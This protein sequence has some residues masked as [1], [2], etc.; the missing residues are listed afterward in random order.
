MLRR[1]LPCLRQ[2][3]SVKHVS[4]VLALGC[5]R[6][7]TQMANSVGLMVGERG[8]EPP[9]PWSRTN[10][11]CTK[12]LFRLGLFCVLLCP[13]VWFSGANGPRL[14]PRLDSTFRARCKISTRNR[15]VLL[16][17]TPRRRFCWF[18]PGKYDSSVTGSTANANLAG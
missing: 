8:F 14:D 15:A 9:T 7:E 6:T 5:S 18:D 3:W 4:G 16:V 1:K 11:R 2:A 17:K 12:L 13:P 10:N